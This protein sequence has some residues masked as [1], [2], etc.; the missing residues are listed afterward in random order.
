[1]TFYKFRDEID[2]SQ[3]L[4]T[5]LADACNFKDEFD[6]SLNISERNKY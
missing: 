6:D 3:K 1:L 2:I 5:I 4:G